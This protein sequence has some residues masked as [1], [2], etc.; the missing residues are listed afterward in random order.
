MSSFFN[1][2]FPMSKLKYNDICQEI[3]YISDSVYF[4]FFSKPMK[5]WEAD[6][7]KSFLYVLWLW[8]LLQFGCDDFKI[9]RDTF[10]IWMINIV[11]VLSN[12]IYFLWDVFQYN[13][14]CEDNNYFCS[15]YKIYLF[16]FFAHTAHYWN[17]M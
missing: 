10:P 9:F 17:T 2:T 5:I 14:S 4:Y 13:R 1:L 11:F 16:R 6:I 3:Y 12:Y 7:F 8:L 15:K